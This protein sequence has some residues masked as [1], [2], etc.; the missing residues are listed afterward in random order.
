MS[1]R[2]ALLAVMGAGFL[3]GCQNQKKD[4]DVASAQNASI[5]YGAL[6]PD[7]Y[8][9]SS[10]NTA[11]DP[12][13]SGGAYPGGA[14]TQGYDSATG[15]THKVSKGDTLFGLAR[16]YYNDAS[17]WKDIYAA[18]RDTLS[19]PNKLRVGQDLVIP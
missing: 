3:C 7:L 14:S 15:R 8:S 6:P 19:D 17:R 11:S 16:T 18:N 13:D 10:N 12:Y 2:I 4:A 5:D 1:R 9:S